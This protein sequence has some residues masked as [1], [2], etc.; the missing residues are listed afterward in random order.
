MT[1]AERLRGLIV[2]AQSGYYDVETDRGTITAQL[3]G[4]LKQE[5]RETDLATVGDRVQ[6]SLLEDGSGVIEVVE[7]RERALSRRYPG[8]DVEQVIV[9]NPDQAIVVFACADPDPNFRMLDRILVVTEREGIP[10]VICA[11]KIDLVDLRSAKAE[12]GEYAG[13]G[14]RVLY[15]SAL[16]GKGIRALRKL[17]YDRLSVLAGPSGVGK[18][19][20]LNAVEPGLGLRTRDVSQVTGKGLHTTVVRELV[21]LARG[22]YV[23]DTPG[24]KAFALWDVEPEELD[25]YFREIAPLVA[26]CEFSDCTH[27]HEP[28][29]AVIAALEAGGV[30]PERY[31]SYVRMRLGE[32]ED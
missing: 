31:D 10:T 2:R 25:A 32:E 24:L 4:R 15:T 26:K 18:T 23:A 8:R 20:L 13:L 5:R 1:E 17:L 27:V 29:C 28:G 16:T 19:S 9:A 21:P 6:L 3:R 22:G 14:Y 7:A 30:S 11:N 12:F